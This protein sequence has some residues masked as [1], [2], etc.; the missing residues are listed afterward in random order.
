MDTLNLRTENYFRDLLL[1]YFA[2]QPLI[3]GTTAAIFLAAVVIAF[4]S[5]EVFSAE[6]SILL[7][8]NEFQRSPD[9]V[10]E[11]ELRA[12]R[13]D[14]QDLRSER[15]ILLSPRVLNG[16][17]VKLSQAGFPY[18]DALTVSN[19]LSSLTVTVI[20]DTKVLD[21]E[22]RRPTPEQATEILDAVI[23]EYMIE[24]TQILNPERTSDF[25]AIQAER[26]RSQL[27]STKEQL[28]EMAAANKTADPR[29]EIQSNI[30]FKRIL[31]ERL[32]SLEIEAVQYREEL[33]HLDEALGDDQIRLFSFIGRNDTVS[34]L[35]Q[36]LVDLSIERGELARN[37]E[38]E[39]RVVASV[40]KQLLETAAQVRREAIDYRDSLATKLETAE[41]QQELIREQIAT[42]DS[43]NV[44]LQIHDIETDSLNR[45]L[46]LIGQSFSTFFRRNQ[47]SQIPNSVDG[48][49]SLFYVSV[50]SPA[51]TSGKAVFPNRPLILGL[52]LFA[53]FLTGF[54]L[55]FIRE[56]IDHTFKVPRDVEQYLG[57]PLLFS[58]PLLADSSACK[59]DRNHSFTG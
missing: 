50:L 34:S 58:T 21:L 3:L 17:I 29:A 19:L 43:R 25:F 23:E 33:R 48:K 42:V 30:A 6:A 27:G 59:A 11:T 16:A 5:A 54:T 1:I 18:A 55:G 45:E 28:V 12:F 26:F 37:Y 40:D 9:T 14:E 7:R 41:K 10:Q 24:R 15:E 52:G 51:H 20:P 13:V 57:V 47:E 44:D 46:E 32:N 36:R 8:S 38:D 4:T 22:L 31:Q 56:F 53:G 35:V 39:S 49:V 2:R